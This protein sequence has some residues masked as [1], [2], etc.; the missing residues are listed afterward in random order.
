MTRLRSRSSLVETLEPADD[1]DHRLLRVAEGRVQG[2]QLALHGQARIGRQGA[3]QGLG[4]GVG[5]VGGAEGVVDIE[6]AQRGQLRGEGRIVLFLARVEADVFQQGDAA[7]RQ[8]GDD[9]GGLIADAVTGEGHRRAQQGGRGSATK[10]RLICGTTLPLGRSKWASSATL[11]PLPV[12]YW[13]VGRAERRRVSSVILPP[14]TG[15][16]KS[17]DPGRSCR[18]D[19]RCRGC[20]RSWASLVV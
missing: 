10:A 20:G 9:L 2:F 7:G 14:S 15:T 5:A 13:M 16:L 1:A 19:R 12:R 4:R 6:V 18:R 17:T 8:S 3:G 11:A